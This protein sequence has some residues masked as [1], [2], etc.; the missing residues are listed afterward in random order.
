MRTYWRSYFQGT[1]LLVFVVDS[2]DKRR[3]QERFITSN[4]SGHELQSLLEEVKLLRVPLLVYANKQDLQ[5]ALDGDQVF[6]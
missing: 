2:S 3:L 5:T 4:Y 6:S 1:D